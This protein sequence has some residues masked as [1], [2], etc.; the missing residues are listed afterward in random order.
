MQIVRKF[1]L[2]LVEVCVYMCDFF[3]IYVLFTSFILGRLVYLEADPSGKIAEKGSTTLPHEISAVNIN[4]I[5]DQ[6]DINA[7]AGVCVVSL[8]NDIR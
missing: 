5:G 4:L 2:P 3:V 6:T 7:K 1:W 8:W